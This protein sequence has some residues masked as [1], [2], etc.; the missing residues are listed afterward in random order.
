MNDPKNVPPGDESSLPT[1]PNAQSRAAYF[2]DMLPGVIA[3]DERDG[4]LA[5]ALKRRRSGVPLTAEEVR[6][7]LKAVLS[8]L[9]VSFMQYEHS[10][11][12]FLRTPAHALDYAERV[13]AYA[14]KDYP[15]DFEADADITGL[16]DTLKTIHLIGYGWRKGEDKTDGKTLVG[17][18]N[19][20]A[21]E[22][23]NRLYT[24]PDA[25]NYRPI[26]TDLLGVGVRS[27]GSNDP[28]AKMSKSDIQSELDKANA[29]DQQASTASPT[30]DAAAAD[31][32]KADAEDAATVD[33]VSPEAPDQSH[34]VEEKA[35]DLLVLEETDLSEKT[36][37]PEEKAAELLVPEQT[38]NAAEQS[39]TDAVKTADQ[40]DA[41]ASPSN[42]REVNPA[43]KTDKVSKVETSE[44]ADEDDKIDLS[45]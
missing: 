24:N 15:R 17:T 35:A 45:W 44:Q 18:V 9:T 41:D 31:P 33:K 13:A 32:V 3:S 37:A 1:T 4:R 36:D 39:E 16:W 2:E 30:A 29:A 12:T 6:R 26:K 27:A 19:K 40:S 42:Q 7:D 14:M 38:V 34:G 20:I 21:N 10:F 25:M 28:T 23:L 22:A 8:Q 43:D 11:S 5:Q